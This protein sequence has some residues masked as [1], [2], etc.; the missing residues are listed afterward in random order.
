[1]LKNKYIFFILFILF[2]SNFLPL[3]TG[4]PRGL[5]ILLSLFLSLILNIHK[6]RKIFINKDI[7]LSYCFLFF[8][9][10][11]TLFISNFQK[12]MFNYLVILSTAF[13]IAFLFKNNN[14]IQL[15]FYIAIYISVSNI[16]LFINMNTHIIPF[17]TRTIFDGNHHRIWHYTLFGSYEDGRAIWFFGE[18]SEYVQFIVPA[19]ILALYKNKFKLAS[20]FTISMFFSL[21][22]SI[23]P[24][25]IFIILY[26][27][28]NSYK[29]Y[30]KLF[31]LISISIVFILIYPYF[32]HIFISRYFD[33][34]NFNPSRIIQLLNFF[35]NGGTA[36]NNFLS[37]YNYSS[38][39]FFLNF[40][41]YILII[42][43]IYMRTRNITLSYIL[44]FLLI[45]SY[46]RANAAETVFYW[47]LLFISLQ[48]NVSKNNI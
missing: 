33:N 23:I 9:V 26:L 43:V 18:P 11:E 32:E 40:T 6:N 27:L 41:I 16:L 12:D 46:I 37:I 20:L 2:Q 21:S 39:M 1:M 8:I 44:F 22:A 29:F 30:F 13:F 34:E 7:L 14:L 15:Y 17:F 42:I 4:L 47:M 36:L 5:F 19:I 25:I 10:L 45:M 24:G 35:K 28:L 3:W 48:K 38:L 31:I